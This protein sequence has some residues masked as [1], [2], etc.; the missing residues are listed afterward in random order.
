M[1]KEN[2]KTPTAFALKHLVQMKDEIPRWSFLEHSLSSL[3]VVIVFCP[4]V[5]N[6]TNDVWKRRVFWYETAAN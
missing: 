1:N 6:R 4:D 3:S 5:A 2:L